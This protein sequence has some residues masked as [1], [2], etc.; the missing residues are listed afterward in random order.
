M[1]SVPPVDARAKRYGRQTY[2][3]AREADRGRAIGTLQRCRRRPARAQVNGC[4]GSTILRAPRGRPSSRY[5]K[6][7]RLLFETGLADGARNVLLAS[8]ALPEQPRGVAAAREECSGHLHLSFGLANL[9]LACLGLP[10]R[11]IALNIGYELDDHRSNAGDVI[12]DSVRHSIDIGDEASRTC[13]STLRL[14]SLYWL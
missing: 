14:A 10:V 1:M 11:R 12:E 6:L 2:F 5:H 3:G 9:G 8:A 7:G 4:D 13:K